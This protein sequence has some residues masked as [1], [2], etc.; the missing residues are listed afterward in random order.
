MLSLEAL[1][2]ISLAVGEAKDPN[3][4]CLQMVSSGAFGPNCI[5]ISIY[6]LTQAGTLERQACQG[7]QVFEAPEE[8][9]LFSQNPLSAALGG[10]K[11]W[12]RLVSSSL[13]KSVV[14]VF[15]I[16]RGFTPFGCLL[17]TWGES[18]VVRE[19]S[20][21]LDF[22]L[23]RMLGVFLNCPTAG[24][25]RNKPLTLS[26]RQ[27]K[28]LS[29]MAV[30]RTNASIARELVLSESSIKQEGVKIFKYLGVRTRQDAVDKAKA[31]G[32]IP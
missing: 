31:E 3:E 11:T 21:E 14:S 22:I 24:Q 8:F 20:A 26:S 15:P 29:L 13:G 23:S 28:I 32:L 10:N 5:G 25:S 6:T 9:S 7:F 18:E 1:A 17:V 16:F 27:L 19:N 4:L 30:G 12:T 2:K